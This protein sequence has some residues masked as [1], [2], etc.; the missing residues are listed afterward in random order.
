M[1]DVKFHFPYASISLD[2]VS[3]TRVIEWKRAILSGVIFTVND[4]SV[5]YTINPSLLTYM[6]Q[7]PHRSWSF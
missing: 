5:T 2:N 3:D 7:R 6:E 4:D 1:Y